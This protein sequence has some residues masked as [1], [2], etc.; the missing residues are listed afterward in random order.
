METKYIMNKGTLSRK[1][2]SICF[3]NEKEK[4]NYIPIEGIKTIYCLDEVSLNTKLID[5]LGKKGII[6]HLFNHYEGYSGSF[7]PREKYIS[8]KLT[9][10]QVDFFHHHRIKIAKSIV[11][12]IANN[13]HEVLYHYYRH[14]KKDLKDF[15]DWLKKEVEKELEKVEEINQIMA[16]EGDIWQ[17]FYRSFSLILPEDF[18]MNKRVKRPP[19]NPINALISF[20]NSILYTKTINQIYQ[21]HLD[22][23]ISFLHSPSEGRFSLS[24]DLSEV[25][26][27]IIVFKTIFDC[28]NNRKLRVE[29]HFDKKVNYCLLNGK[30]KEIFIG[31][32]E[33]RMNTTF[34]HTK[35]KRKVK[36]ITG[37]KYDGYKLIKAIM[38]GEEF[39]PFSIKEKC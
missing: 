24:L 33:E 22:Q 17:K 14:G 2:N 21:T 29:Q 38:E 15:I 16:I 28:I 6:L 36:L 20:G 3:R 19:D 12:G 10:N 5:F 31:A 34:I 4:N 26:K 13:I 35:L 23:S 39:K 18:I 32:L 11:L 8:G 27:P 1:D 30:G 25:F 9:I 7:Y 37:I